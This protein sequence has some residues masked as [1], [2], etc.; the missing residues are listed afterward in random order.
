MNCWEQN[1]ANALQENTLRCLN[2]RL[3]A[4]HKK[5]VTQMLLVLTKDGKRVKSFRFG[6]IPNWKIYDY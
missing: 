4:D 6:N 5:Q 1:L 2:K 3:F